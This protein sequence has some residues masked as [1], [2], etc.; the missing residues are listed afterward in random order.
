MDF[1]TLTPHHIHNILK[2]QPISHALI[3]SSGIITRQAKIITSVD[4]PA[5]ADYQTSNHFVMASQFDC[6][7]GGCAAERP[8]GAA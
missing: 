1:C 2:M 4:L 8:V 3:T 5:V 7:D 6:T